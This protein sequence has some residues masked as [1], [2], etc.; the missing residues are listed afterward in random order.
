MARKKE[1]QAPHIP[2]Q[3]DERGHEVLDATPAA[4]PVR[5]KGYKPGLTEE[6][7][8]AMHYLSLEAEGKERESF[9]DADDFEV[10]DDDFFGAKT[11]YEVD[12]EQLAYDAARH[13]GWF[14]GSENVS[15]GT[16]DEKQKPV[17][18]SGKGPETS[19]VGSGNGEQ[20][21][22]SNSDGRNQGNKS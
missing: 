16:S 21:A 17:Q 19:G 15:G 5:F 20:P 13:E 12:E 9:E 22:L 6:V 3:L 2:P 8:R 10:D 11:V 1:F 18:P 7:Q 4:I 14:A